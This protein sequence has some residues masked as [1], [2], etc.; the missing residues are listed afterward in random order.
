LADY[1]LASPLFALVL[2][3]DLVFPILN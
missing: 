2:F 3:I 1:Y